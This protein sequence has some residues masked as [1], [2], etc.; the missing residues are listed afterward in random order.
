MTGAEATLLAGLVGGGSA[1]LAAGLATF[2][3]Y[4]VTTR[5][6]DAQ[7]TRARE[8]RLAE[9]YIDL[10]WLIHTAM[11]HVARTRQ[12]QFVTT[13]QPDSPM[14]ASAEEW[15]IRARVQAIGSEA[16]RTRLREWHNTA[17]RFNGF[18]GELN[19]MS[20]GPGAPKPPDVP[21]HVWQPIS[22]Q[23]DEARVRLIDQALD[24]ERAIRSELTGQTDDELNPPSRSAVTV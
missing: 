2:G 9:A 3:T 15:R 8:E 20:G 19:Q 18:G 13:D 10:V 14:V 24:L 22:E 4:R 23:M 12:P 5:S 16:V 11:F 6:V 21:D 1:V 17:I 7:T